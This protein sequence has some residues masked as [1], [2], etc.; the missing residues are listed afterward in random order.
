MQ[1]K[2]DRSARTDTL[3]AAYA[4]TFAGEAEPLG[5]FFDRPFQGGKSK[6]KWH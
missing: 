4:D 2:K 1:M 3:L 5:Y 6:S